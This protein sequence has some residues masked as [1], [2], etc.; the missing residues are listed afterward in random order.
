MASSQAR[1]IGSA[2]R[3]HLNDKTGSWQWPAIGY[4]NCAAVKPCDRQ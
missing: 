1:A 2:R 3:R 4:F